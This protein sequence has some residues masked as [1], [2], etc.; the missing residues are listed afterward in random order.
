MRYKVLKQFDRYTL[1]EVEL[2]TGRH[3]QI[4]CQLSGISGRQSPT[5]TL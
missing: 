3:H 5:P 2:L 4:R 1:V